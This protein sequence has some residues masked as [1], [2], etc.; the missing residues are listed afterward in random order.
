MRLVR[1]VG[2]RRRLPLDGVIAMQRPR[3]VEIEPARHFPRR[4]VAEQPRNTGL[5]SSPPAARDEADVAA[6]QPR[7][8]SIANSYC[9]SNASF[10]DIPQCAGRQ[11]RG[12]SSR[13]RRGNRTRPA[14]IAWRRRP[15]RTRAKS[16]PELT[17]P[18]TR[19]KRAV[20]APRAAPWT[21]YKRH[22]RCTAAAGRCHHVLV[23]SESEGVQAAGALCRHCSGVQTWSAQR[24]RASRRE[25]CQVPQFAFQGAL[26]ERARPPGTPLP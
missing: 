25:L 24:N 14:A 18:K 7:R 17:V 4:R 11:T 3:D 8:M 26:F 22:G 2:V 20:T 5:E 6:P 21:S 1:R 9:D 15:A 13:A 23:K 10:A 19:P 12:A 16:D